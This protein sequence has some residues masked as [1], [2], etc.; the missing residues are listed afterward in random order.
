MIPILTTP[1]LVLRPVTTDDFLDICAYGRDEETGQY[2]LHWPKTPE[3]IKEYIDEC[4][5]SMSSTTPTWFEFSVIHKDTAKMI[6]TIS[7]IS[8]GDEAELGWM[9]HPA[10]RRQGLMS[11]AA[12]EMIRYAFD[13]LDRSAVWATCTAQN[14]A[15]VRL[16]EKLGMAV[17]L[18]EPQKKVIKNDREIFLDR[19]MYRMSRT[20][21]EAR[22]EPKLQPGS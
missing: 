4:V 2:M 9:L 11:E 16:L 22:Q 15:S 13:S 12:A 3:Q 8:E 6:G 10:F 7:L 19:L 14:I 21:W 5:A 17:V 1:R 20:E 18:S